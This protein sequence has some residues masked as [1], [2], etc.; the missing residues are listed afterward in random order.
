[1]N[2]FRLTKIFSVTL[3]VIVITLVFFV[4]EFVFKLP[5]LNIIASFFDYISSLM[6]V[7]FYIFLFKP[8]SRT[9]MQLALLLFPISYILL[10]LKRNSTA[11]LLA[12]LSYF[13]LAIYLVQLFREKE[14]L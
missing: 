3:K 2:N 14:T 10:L 6:A 5:Y 8:K 12:V 13:F 1:M 4:T 9:L 7:I 11:E